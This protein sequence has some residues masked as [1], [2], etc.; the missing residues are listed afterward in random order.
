MYDNDDDLIDVQST[1][2][3][4]VTTLIARGKATDGKLEIRFYVKWDEDDAVHQVTE[5]VAKILLKMRELEL[6]SR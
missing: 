3:G 6:G 2:I 1:P 4:P 5:E